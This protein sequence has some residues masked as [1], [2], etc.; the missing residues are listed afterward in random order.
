[1][2]QFIRRV[3][4]HTPYLVAICIMS[5]LAVGLILG[6]L[7]LRPTQD[8]TLLIGTGVGFLSSNTLGILALLKAQKTHLIVSSKLDEIIAKAAETS[9][10]DE[11]NAMAQCI[12]IQAIKQHSDATKL[13]ENQ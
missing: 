7:M 4:S 10:R 8:N 1:M 11:S 9:C 5:G 6:V 2:T 3:G 13:E 12:L